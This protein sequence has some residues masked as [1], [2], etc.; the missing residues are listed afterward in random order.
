MTTS[1]VPAALVAAASVL[2]VALASTIADAQPPVVPSDWR[3]R[4][5]PL[6]VG[7]DAS[8][9]LGSTYVSDASGKFGDFTGLDQD[10]FYAVVDGEWRTALDDGRFWSLQVDDLGLESR[11]VT[12]D[13]GRPGAYRAQIQYDAMPKFRYDEIRTPYVPSG[14]MTLPANWVTAGSTAGFTALPATGRALAIGHDRERFTTRLDWNSPQQLDYRA[15]FR[16]D[17]RSGSQLIAGSFAAVSAWLPAPLEYVTDEVELAVGRTQAAS[18]F[19]IGYRGSRFSND[20]PVVEWQNP[21]TPLV[22]GAD[23][24]RLAMAPSNRMRQLYASGS[25]RVGRTQLA[26]Q[27][28]SGRLE[29]DEPFLAATIN[30]TLGAVALPR[31]SLN[32]KVD[33]QRLTVDLASRLSSRLRVTAR[34]EHDDRDNRTAVAEFTNVLTD[35]AAVGVR[36]NMPYDFAR[37]RVRVEA[38]LRLPQRAGLKVGAERDR[39]DRQLQAREHTDEN[40]AWFELDVRRWDSARITAGVTERR[41]RGSDYTVLDRGGAL[42]NP[43]LRQYHVADRDQRIA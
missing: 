32:G 25:L 43:R 4:Y 5:C 16:R 33:T 12:F 20:V 31:S 15:D 18:T 8:W 7:S 23:F 14:R 21:F 41:R 29:Q 42:Q 24:G 35:L 11:S 2:L 6:D 22:A 19:E 30:P 39:W 27:L 38:D 17:T 13:G 36:T 37:D 1:D 40:A 9:W 26:A 34:L 28:S 3:C 10:G